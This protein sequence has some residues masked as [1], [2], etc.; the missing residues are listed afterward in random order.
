MAALREKEIQLVRMQRKLEEQEK[1]IEL[2]YQQVLNQQLKEREE[3]IQKR[4]QESMDMRIKEKDKQLEDQ[5][6]LI[7]EMKRKAEELE[8]VTKLGLESYCSVRSSLNAEVT[9]ECKIE[10]P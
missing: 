8:K 7:E 2:K 1:E 10:R 4:I 5:R 6:K 9:F 3:S